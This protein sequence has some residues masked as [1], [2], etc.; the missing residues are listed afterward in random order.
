[1]DLHSIDLNDLTVDETTA[2]I[3][4]DPCIWVDAFLKVNGNPSVDELKWGSNL[5]SINGFDIKS[6]YE[7]GDTEGGGDYSEV[8]FA[9]TY[10]GEKLAYFQYTGFYSSYCGTEWND[11]YN[12][13]AP[14]E[15]TLTKYKTA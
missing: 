13:V 11:N 3:Q 10:Q 1:M 8:V 15:V 2:I 7:E 6:V 4:R 12:I 14:Y 5:D 9:I